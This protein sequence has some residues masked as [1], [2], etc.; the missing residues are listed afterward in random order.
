MVVILALG[1][2]FSYAKAQRGRIITWVGATFT[3][4]R[5]S[6]VA[7]I[8][9]EIL[10][11]LRAQSET[12]AERNVVPL[13]DLKSYAGRSSHVAGLLEAWRPFLA[14]LWAALCT[15]NAKDTNA[16]KNTVWTVQI[17]HTIQWIQSFLQGTSGSLSRTFRLDAYLNRGLRIEVTLDA[18]PFGMGAY[19]KVQDKILQYYIT[20]VSVHDEEILGFTRGS[21]EG[22]QISES[23]NALVAIRKWHRIW[24]QQRMRLKIRGDSVAMLYNSMTLRARTPSLALIAREIALL[25][26][27]SSFMPDIGEHVPGIANIIADTLSRKYDPTVK[28]WQLPTALANARAVYV[29]LRD[30]S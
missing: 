22:Q 13:K 16:P 11:D 15:A 30:E 14:E 27:E 20:E 24:T 19:I 17:L 10:D 26:A 2:P 28:D 6:L 21:S 1:F 3:L 23:L 25:V 18:S 7:E 8:R 5:R 9:Q 4:Q 12:L 29:P